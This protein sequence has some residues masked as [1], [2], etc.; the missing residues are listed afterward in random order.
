MAG[1]YRALYAVWEVYGE[2]EDGDEDEEP[3]DPPKPP[4]RETGAGVVAEFASLL[5]QMINLRVRFSAG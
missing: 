2:P 5:E 4:D 3:D 1:D